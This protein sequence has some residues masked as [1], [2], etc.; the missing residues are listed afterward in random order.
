MNIKSITKLIG[1]KVKT[2]DGIGILL[3]KRTPLNVLYYENDKTEWTVWYGEKTQ[4][5][6]V[7]KTYSSS[8]IEKISFLDK[9]RIILGELK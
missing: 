9:I 5:G 6:W 4:N 7:S 2:A 1:K 8:E 3:N